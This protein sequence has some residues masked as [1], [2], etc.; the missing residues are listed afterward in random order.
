MTRLV[1]EKPTITLQEIR[2]ISISPTSIHK[3]LEAKIYKQKIIIPVPVTMNSDN[4][5]TNTEI[6]CQ[7]IDD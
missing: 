4:I 1:D 5:K 7:K 2:K 3:Y 6:L